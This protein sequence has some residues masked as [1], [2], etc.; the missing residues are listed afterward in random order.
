MLRDESIFPDASAFIPERY[1][2]N[3]SEE[4]ARLR[5]PDMYVFGFGRRKCPGMAFARSSVWIAMVSILSCF[6]VESELD[7]EKTPIPLQPDVVV[8]AIQFV[9]PSILHYVYI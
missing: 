2:T 5:D 1:N 4:L 7:D 9:S 8:G 6:R 3:V